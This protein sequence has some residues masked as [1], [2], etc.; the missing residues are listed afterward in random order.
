M[1][2]KKQSLLWEVSFADH[3]HTSYVFGTM[4]IK[5]SSVFSAFDQI[6]SYIDSCDAFCTE[7]DMSYSTDAELQS[8]A[9][10]P[11]HLSLSTLLSEKQVYRLNQILSS[12]KGPSVAQLNQVRPLNIISLLS[13]LILQG[14]ESTI[15]DHSLYQYAQSKDKRTFGI[16]TKEEHMAILDAMT[17]DK[18]LKQLKSIIR[19]FRPFQKMHHKMLD[20][21]VNGRIDTLHKNGK[22]SLGS[23]RRVLLKERNQKMANRISSLSI[24]ESIFCAVGAAHLAGKFGVLRL[25]KQNGAVIKPISLRF[26]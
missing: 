15:L 18:E 2:K 12:I 23:W 8:K 9:M 10:L 16:E 19:D 1:K 24:E 5:S 25:L 11:A 22:K 13:G 7:I 6:S 20:H 4:H 3:S 17:L 26:H 14:D 21:Y